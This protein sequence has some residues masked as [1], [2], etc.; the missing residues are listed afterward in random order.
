MD[1][2]EE[3]IEDALRLTV[4]VESLAPQTVKVDLP[5]QLGTRDMYPEQLHYEQ[6]ALFLFQKMEGMDVMLFAAYM[7]EFGADA[8]PNSRMVYLNYVDS[9]NYMQPRWLR[10]PIYHELLQGKPTR[11]LA[12]DVT[13]M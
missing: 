8:G 2:S 5:E 10:T 6:V 12:F 3:D 4:R 13:N 7:N 1:A 11:S 9:V